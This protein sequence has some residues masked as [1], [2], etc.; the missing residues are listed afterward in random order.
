MQN[1]QGNL[2]ILNIIILYGIPFLIGTFGFICSL[3]V[4]KSIKFIGTLLIILS[5]VACCVLGYY[6]LMSGLIGTGI[7]GFGLI[8]S[9]I[10]YW[11]KDEVF[12]EN[13]VESKDETLNKIKADYGDVESL[14]KMGKEYFII[15]KSVA[16]NYFEQAAEKGNA[17]AQYRLG[18]VYYEFLER[19]Q[20]GIEWLKKSAAQN[21]KYAIDKLN[22]IAGLPKLSAETTR[23][24]T[25]N[26]SDNKEELK[27]REKEKIKRL[28]MLKNEYNNLKINQFTSIMITKPDKQLEA[29]IKAPQGDY[30]HEAILAAKQEKIRREIIKIELSNLSN[31]KLLDFLKQK[32]NAIDK[33]YAREEAENRNLITGEMV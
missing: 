24:K 18:R 21:Y 32:H 28:E 4:N 6:A 15:N 17:E 9:L 19:K 16:A 30:N 8:G 2:I 22:N 10:Y 31:E 27:K 26:I 20:E 12:N 5:A 25:L 7:S 13:K 3:S 11:L 14:I 29:T 23:E 1:L 33:D